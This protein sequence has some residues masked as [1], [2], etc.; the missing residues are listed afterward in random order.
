MRVGLNS[1]ALGLNGS[2]ELA[3]CPLP[4]VFYTAL[5]VVADVRNPMIIQYN[6]I[7][8]GSRLASAAGGL[9]RDD[10]L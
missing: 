6:R 7:L 5:T 8:S 4:Y 9:G 10:E 2:T 1:A 3:E